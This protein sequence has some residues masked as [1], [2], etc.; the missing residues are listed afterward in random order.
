[1]MPAFHQVRGRGR[2]AGRGS[3]RGRGM[4]MGMVRIR[5]AFSVSTQFMAAT[6]R[7]IGQPKA[8]HGR[9]ARDTIRSHPDTALTTS[10][11]TTLHSHACKSLKQSRRGIQDGILECKLLL[12]LRFEEHTTSLAPCTNPSYVQSGR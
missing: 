7:D 6:V 8:N 3:G 10:H 9:G 2:G 12:K 4:G 5:W 11:T 1:M